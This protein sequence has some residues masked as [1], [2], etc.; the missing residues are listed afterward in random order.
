MK[1]HV[2]HISGV[3]MGG[4]HLWNEPGLCMDVMDMSGHV[5]DGGGGGIHW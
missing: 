5:W 4:A 3:W 1:H 2:E